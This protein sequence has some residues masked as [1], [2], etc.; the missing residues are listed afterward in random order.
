MVILGPFDTTVKKALTEIDANWPNYPGL[1]VCGSHTPYEPEKLIA[2]IEEARV[3]GTP[4]LG[5]CYGHQL[6]AIEFARNVL[7]IE[8]ATSEEWGTGTFVVQ[9]RPELNVGLHNGETYWNN[10][11]VRKDIEELWVKPDNFI[12]V[13]FHPEYQSSVDKP[14][15]I[16]K[17]FLQICGNADGLQH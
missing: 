1:V 10:Y 3:S 8:D 7:G 15:P 16:L 17:Q 14:H 12:T 4:F 13:Q 2:R 5:I 6:A 11:E 9:K